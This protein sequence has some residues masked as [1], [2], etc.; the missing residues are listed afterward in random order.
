MKT[1]NRKPKLNKKPSKGMKNFFKQ[2][3]KSLK[4]IMRKTSGPT[5]RPDQQWY[6]HKAVRASWLLSLRGSHMPHQG[7]KECA[8]RVRQMANATHGYP[9]FNDSRHTYPTTVPCDATS[10]KLV[11][12]VL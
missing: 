3:V 10:Q 4:N 2:G 5:Q 12:M 7:P 6:T 9:T 11:D 1:G 8:R